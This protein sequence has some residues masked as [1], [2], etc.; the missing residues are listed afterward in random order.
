MGIKCV[1]LTDDLMLITSEGV[2]IRTGCDSIRIC[3][4]SSQG[5]ILMRLAEGV[6]VIS[7]A[8]TAREEDEADEASEQNTAGA[9]PVNEDEESQ[10]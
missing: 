2:I 1:D 5:V 8:R 7:L 4:R 3:G 9:D 6:K 10:G